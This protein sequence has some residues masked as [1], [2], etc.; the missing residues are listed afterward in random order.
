MDDR[1]LGVDQIELTRVVGV[2]QIEEY[3]FAE[4]SGSSGRANQSDRA[5][6]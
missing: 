6:L 1:A 3:A 5:R 2:L 4:R